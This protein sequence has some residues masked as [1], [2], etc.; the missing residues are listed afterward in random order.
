MLLLSWDSVT[1]KITRGS[2]LPIGR[3]AATTVPT[4]DC[5]HISEL[6]SGINALPIICCGGLLRE[7]EI[8]GCTSLVLKPILRHS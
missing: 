4:K 2:K 8:H 3:E 7:F 6:E 1:G 5:L